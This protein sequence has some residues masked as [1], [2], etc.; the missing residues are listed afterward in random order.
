V[1]AGWLPFCSLVALAAFGLDAGPATTIGLF[2]VLFNAGHLGLRAWGLA[3]G[4]K[5]GLRVA[6]ALGNPVLRR[7]PAQIAR[8]AAVAAGVALPLALY[9]VIGPARTLITGRRIRL[10][11]TGTLT[12]PFVIGRDLTLVAGVFA[13]VVVGA[14]LIVRLRGRVEGWRLALWGLAAFVL[15]SVIR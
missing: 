7:G 6:S 2:L 11:L 12:H 15:Y 4:W 8:L 5:R 3:V 10:P 14:I 13:L 1:W 9:R